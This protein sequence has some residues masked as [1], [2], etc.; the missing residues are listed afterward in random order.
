VRRCECKRQNL[1]EGG[2]GMKHCVR[3]SKD[4]PLSPP[5]S[6]KAF[7]LQ[8]P[9]SSFF[10]FVVVAVLWILKSCSK[11]LVSKVSLE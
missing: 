9:S 7:D 4:V 1:W 5:P 6:L 3:S 2:G 8:A 11:G 10:F